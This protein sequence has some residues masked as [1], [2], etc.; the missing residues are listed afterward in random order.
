MHAIHL[1]GIH[2]P[3]WGDTNL[4]ADIALIE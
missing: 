1:Y 4:Y 2:L 3:V